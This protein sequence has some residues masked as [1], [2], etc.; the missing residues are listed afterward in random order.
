M[1]LKT[2]VCTSHFG[3]VTFL[4]ACSQPC[5]DHGT[6]RFFC[7]RTRA[8]NDSIGYLNI[9]WM[10]THAPFVSHNASPDRVSYA[11]VLHHDMLRLNRILG[12]ALAPRLPTI[13]RYAPSRPLPGRLKAA[14]FARQQS[15]HVSAE[16]CRVPGPT[17]WRI[18]E[19]ILCGFR[20]SAAHI[21]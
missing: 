2:S 3:W 8:D 1:P 4:A 6:S 17:I 9:G 12:N 14:D 10:N 18:N 20:H 5:V 16:L 7:C 19:T 21:H 11:P 13:C 15:P